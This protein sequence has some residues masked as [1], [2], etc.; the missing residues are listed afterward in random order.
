[1]SLLQKGSLTATLAP[2]P[3]SAALRGLRVFV[4]VQVRREGREEKIKIAKVFL[5]I[6]RLIL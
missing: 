2:H 1:M 5:K 4:A 6:F 3:R